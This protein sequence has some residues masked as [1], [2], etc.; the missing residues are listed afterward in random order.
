MSDIDKEIWKEDL[1]GIP[2]S[3]DGTY[4]WIELEHGQVQVKLDDE[5][6]VVDLFD[7][8]D[9][10]VASTYATYSELKGEFL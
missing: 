4:I 1:N 6:V 9:E 2:V 5:G 7:A 3:T 8:E 10:S